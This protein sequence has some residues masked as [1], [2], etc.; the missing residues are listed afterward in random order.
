MFSGIPYMNK[1]NQGNGE[2]SNRRNRSNNSSNKSKSSS[3]SSKGRQGHNKPPQGAQKAPASQSL[4]TRHVGPVYSCKANGSIVVKHRE[5]VRDISG[6]AAFSTVSLPINPGRVKTFPWLSSLARNYESYLFHKLSF[7]FV[8]SSPSSASGTIALA[9]D[10]DATDSAPSTKSQ[11]MN[12]VE[13]VSGAVWQFVAHH[14]TLANLHKRKSYFV[15]LS[16]AAG[17]DIRISDVGNL[18]IG[19]DGHGGS[20]IIGSLYINYEVELMTPCMEDIGLGGA[21]S[22]VRV[23]T[24][25]AAPF[26]QLNRGSSDIITL[27]SAGT[28]ASV[29]T[30]I[31]NAPWMG[32]ICI[33]LT[34]TDLPA[35]GIVLGG[36]C[37]HGQV[38]STVVAAL[39]NLT[40]LIRVDA[41]E[42][43][44]LIL[45]INNTSITDGEMWMMQ[46]AAYP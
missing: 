2:R 22:Q 1:F 9:V 43:S 42:G 40:D 6:S 37:T 39:T 11:L 4:V 17:A 10:Y 31:F 8:T 25:N 38:S 41:I 36:T 32:T 19:T 34:G 28:T 27:A 20:N 12:Y 46:G 24:T 21:V 33:P 29:T 30:I 16:S 44:T 45:T 18:V 13:T 7:E 35:G 15:R 23:G 14:S 5:Y 3:S 26:G